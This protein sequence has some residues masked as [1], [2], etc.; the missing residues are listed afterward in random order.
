[1]EGGERGSEREKLKLSLDRSTISWE[2]IITSPRMSK[3]SFGGG[4]E[5]LP[6]R[7]KK[8]QEEKKGQQR[9]KKW[10]KRLNS[11]SLVDVDGKKRFK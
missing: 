6:G 1:M 5:R 8:E 7:D 2:I 3:T 11:S 4:E 10:E 9:S